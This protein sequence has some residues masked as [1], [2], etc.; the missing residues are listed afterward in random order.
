MSIEYSTDLYYG[1]QIDEYYDTILN[2]AENFP[3][4]N[5]IT[6]EEFESLC[7]EYIFCLDS[8]SDEGIFLGTRVKTECEYGDAVMKLYDYIEAKNLYEKEPNEEFENFV[9]ILRELIPD[10]PPLTFCIVNQLH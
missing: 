5:I 9:K 2:M 1:C 8:W 4:I 7:D 6:K 10:L 3:D